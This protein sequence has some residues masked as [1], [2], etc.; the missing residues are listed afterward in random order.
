MGPCCNLTG[1]KIPI[2]NIKDS[3]IEEMWN[4]AKMNEVRNGLMKN[5]QIKVCQA[6]IESQENR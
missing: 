4:G 1:K 5:S 3:T 6:C 2:G